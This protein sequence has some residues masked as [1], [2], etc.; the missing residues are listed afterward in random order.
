VLLGR[1]PPRLRLRLRLP[2]RLRLRLRLPPC[3]LQR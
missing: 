1:L 3:L 2:P